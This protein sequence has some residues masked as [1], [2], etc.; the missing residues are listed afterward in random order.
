VIL[1]ECDSVA[2][3]VPYGALRYDP[4]SS[5]RFSLAMPNL[6]LTL[7]TGVKL[8]ANRANIVPPF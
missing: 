2:N 1:F 8:L 6:A 3:E 7:M 5:M 4:S